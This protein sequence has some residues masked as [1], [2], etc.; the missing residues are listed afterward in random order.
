MK[1]ILFIT[2]AA[3]MLLSSCQRAVPGLS[4][5]SAS[6]KELSASGGTVKASVKSDGEWKT[7][8]DADIIVKPSS[9]SGDQS[10]SITVPA[11]TTA[12]GK[13]MEV[14]FYSVLG[15]V[16][17][18]VAITQNAPSVSAKYD[19]RT[20]SPLGETIDVKVTS[21]G[22]WRTYAGEG[23][24]VSPSY[25][26]DNETDAKIVIPANT[27]GGER[28]LEVRFCSALNSSVCDIVKIHQK[29]VFFSVNP[30]RDTVPPTGGTRSFTVTADGE[31]KTIADNGSTVEPGEGS[32][33]A[34]V[35]VKVLANATGTDR[36]VRVV[37]YSIENASLSDT[38]T[39][40]QKTLSINV[41][42]ESDDVSALGGDV[43]FYVE[44]NGR[45]TASAG[46]SITVTPS[47]FEGSDSVTVRV[48]KNETGHNR[49]VSVTFT[50]TGTQ[51]SKTVTIKQE[52]IQ[53]EVEEESIYDVP[54][55]V[56]TVSVT[57]HSNCSWKTQIGEWRYSDGSKNVS[58]QI[59]PNPS[60]GEP[61]DYSVSIIVPENRSK[62]ARNV[63]IKFFYK[64]NSVI[65]DLVTIHQKAPSVTVSPEVLPTVSA[66]GQNVSVK[67][68]SDG[69]WDASDI[70]SELTLSDTAYGGSDEKEVLITVDPNTT[71]QPRTLK[72][73][74]CSK[75]NSSVYKT[76][77]INQGF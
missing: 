50:M 47:T 7:S 46:D 15:E 23:V 14:A 40:H 3:L 54:A 45:W 5:Q 48:P 42:P 77:E 70:S 26:F 18:V 67:V 19:G 27:S 33:G 72:V 62:E 8:T 38:V 16:S 63:T 56:D 49:D 73:K 9:G 31:W 22:G 4:V 69:G 71:T 41:T 44:A 66:F 39:I 59:I 74:F 57:L 35:K 1:H 64:D 51:L 32:G 20:I 17:E 2:A 37:F 53:V 12:A 29:S 30:S 55:S 11:N 34:S 58:D 25:D 68:T 28:D 43:R 6:E 61:G 75:L 24:A 10:V 52:P 36:D 76:V 60:S 13:E 65:S 21:D